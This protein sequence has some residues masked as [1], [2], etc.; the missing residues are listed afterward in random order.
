VGAEGPKDAADTEGGSRRRPWCRRCSSR[1]PPLVAHPRSQ[2]WL[3]GLALRCRDSIYWD[4]VV[5]S[6]KRVRASD[7]PRPITGASSDES[8]HSNEVPTATALNR[9]T[10][11]ALGVTG[12]RL[13]ISPAWLLRSTSP[14]RVA[15]TRQMSCGRDFILPVARTWRTLSRRALREVILATAGGNWSSR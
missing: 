13:V 12:R 15:L 8:R 10:Q 3:S 6:G 5:H 14:P 1:Y 11:R 9:G 2:R 7:W 4:E